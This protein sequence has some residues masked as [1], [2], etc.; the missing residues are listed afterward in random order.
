MNDRSDDSDRTA[1]LFRWGVA[2]DIGNVREKNEDAFLIEAQVGLFG[3]VD[4][5]GGHPGGDLAARSVAEGLAGMMCREFTTMKSRQSRALR[6][7]IDRC[8]GEQSRELCFQGLNKAGFAGMGATVA[9]VLLLNGRVYAANLGDSRVY[10][11]RSGQL[12]RLSRDHS[13]IAEL[14]EAG[15]IGPHEVHGHYASG[16]L[17]QYVG[18]PE[19]ARPHVRSVA[20]EQGDRFLLCTDG[21]TDMIDDV[22]IA[23][24]LAAHLDAQQA[25]ETL[26]QT[27]NEEGGLD[28]TTVVVVDWTG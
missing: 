2:T 28:N 20:L 5:M 22:G 13:V 9:V 16:M 6:G 7:W 8:I 24:M 17:T 4:G 25:A 19:E 21:L 15:E 27:A 1:S 3:V 10:R 23:Q 12:T 11:L 26:V 14:L 18:M